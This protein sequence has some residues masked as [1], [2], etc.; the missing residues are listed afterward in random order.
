MGAAGSCCGPLGAEEWFEESSS[1]ETL[2]LRV[3]YKT[4]QCDETEARGSRFVQCVPGETL[5]VRNLDT[6]I[7]FEPL[8]WRYRDASKRLWPGSYR[9]QV[10][11]RS[12]RCEALGD[13]GRGASQAC[14]LQMASRPDERTESNAQLDVED[15]ELAAS[16]A[17]RFMLHQLSV[18]GGEQTCSLKV[19]VPVVCEVIKS[20]LPALVPVGSF[21]TL[22]SYSATEVQKFVFDGSEP[23]LEI[24]QVFF[25]HAAF[26]SSGKHFVCDIQGE[27]DDDGTWVLVDPC[28]LRAEMPTVAG[29][30]GAAAGGTRRD[31]EDTDREGNVASCG[32]DLTDG[33]A[34]NGPSAAR[35]DTLHP[36]CP[37]LCK[38]FDPHRK[39]CKRN[40]GA[41]G[42]SCGLGGG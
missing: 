35:F 5:V 33:R 40:G 28:V 42:I 9:F 26:S 34:S 25:H 39:S 1:N 4:E 10:T 24:P 14:V 18:S 20:C 6:P 17:H 41:C 30:V 19:A 38:A 37:E 2:V 15:A 11:R 22:A 23:F 29:I 3:T 27:E 31:T 21:C 12:W 13:H 16:Y 36:R 7:G 8:S 32:I